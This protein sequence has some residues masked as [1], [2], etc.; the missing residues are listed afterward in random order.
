M[1]VL[2]IILLSIAALLLLLLLIGFMMPKIVRVEEQ[3]S[4]QLPPEKVFE[5]VS[6]FE[7]FV[8]WSPWSEK[9]PGMKHFFTGEKQSVGSR[10]S[11]EGNS[12][13]GKGYMEITQIIPNER[14]EMDLNFGPQGLAKCGFLL[15]PTAN[16]IQLIWY[17]SSDLGK[18]PLFR[19]MA[20]M[21][22]KF[23]RKDF[24]K[25]LTNLASQ[26]NPT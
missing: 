14:V 9:D 4:I 18:K 21:M 23:V 19:I 2:A 13:V 8:K 12:K 15:T 24:R 3:I 17:F 11:W 20:K 26:L 16:E 1:T 25:G 5:Y 22:D 6:V 7:H 10:Y